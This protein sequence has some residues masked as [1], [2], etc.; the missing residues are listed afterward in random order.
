MIDPLDE[1]IVNFI[2]QMKKRMQPKPPEDNSIKY[3]RWGVWEK[4]GTNQ[5]HEDKARE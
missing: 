5:S 4:Y 1:D 3:G 2:E